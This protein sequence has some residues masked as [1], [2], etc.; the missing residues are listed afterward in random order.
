MSFLIISEGGDGTGL[1]L[2]L[3]EEGHDCRIWIRDP[4]VKDRCKG[5][6]DYADESSI[7]DIIVADCTGSGALLDRYHNAD[8]PI[9]GGSSWADK[10]E[11]DRQYA[12]EVFETCSIKTPKSKRLNQWEEAAEIIQELG[13]ESGK[14]VLK[15]EGSLSGILPSYVSYDLEDAQKTLDSW[16]NQIGENDVDLT[17]QEFKEGVALSTEGWFNGKDWVDGLFNHTIERKHFLNSDLGPSGGCTGNVVWRSERDNPL[18]S[19]LL[20]PLTEV[21]QEH[22]YRGAIDVN[23]V[24][25]E[26]GPFAL[27]FTPRFGYDAFPT[28]LYSLCEFNFGAFL[29]GLAR[30]YDMDQ[31]LKEGYGAGIRLSIP[32]WPSEK[33]K[34]KEKTPIEGL[35]KQMMSWFYPYDIKKNKEGELEGSGAYG[36]LGVM[37]GYGETIEEAFEYAEKRLKRLRIPDKQYRTD[38]AELCYKDFNKVERLINA[39]IS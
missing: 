29:D 17:I 35:T 14:V 33:F 8:V 22:M 37:N 9:V 27:E 20:L 12:E 15:P 11:T 19:E 23:A 4:E 21:L 30:G 7:A 5:L 6:I 26:D 13:A 38:L 1:A 16:K 31:E 18:V 34:A 28:L 32:P 25:T 39:S 36:I 3:K 10:L 2:R 24:L